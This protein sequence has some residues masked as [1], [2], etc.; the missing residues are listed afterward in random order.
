MDLVAVL[1][2]LDAL[3]EAE[4][5]YWV[6]GGWGVDILVGRRTR[7]HRDLDISFD[8]TARDRVIDAL[9]GLGYTMETDQLPSR[10]EFAAPGQRW[11]D[12]HPVELDEHGGGRQHD[13]SDGW[14]QY[15]PGCFTEAVID[16]HRV[17]CLTAAQQMTFHTFYEP[18]PVDLHDIAL[19]NGLLGGH[20]D[21][22]PL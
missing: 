18:R 6:G 14:F 8:H 19:L 21:Q 9:T 1:A 4:V 12:V 10:A 7:D 15:P 5:R 17:P 16:G 22:E 13:L 2:V 20:Y 3:D 11:V